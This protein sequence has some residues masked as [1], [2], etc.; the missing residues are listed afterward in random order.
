MKKPKK[1]FL[2]VLRDDSP[3]KDTQTNNCKIKNSKK[4][5]VSKISSKNN[6]IVNITEKISYETNK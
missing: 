1:I 5:I 6:N 2:K 3:S 4:T